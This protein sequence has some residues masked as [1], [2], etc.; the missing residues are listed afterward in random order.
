[1]PE[2]W[3]ITQENFVANYIPTEGPPLVIKNSLGGIDRLTYENA[4]KRKLINKRRYDTR[5]GGL[6]EKQ[7]K[8]MCGQ[9]V[10]H[11]SVFRALLAGKNVPPEVLRDYSDFVVKP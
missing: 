4:Y 3:Q 10:H 6:T 5:F 11:N 8:Q 1:M 2:I 9:A 7:S